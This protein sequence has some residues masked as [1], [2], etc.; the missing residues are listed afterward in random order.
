MPDTSPLTGVALAQDAKFDG[1]ISYYKE[2]PIGRYAITEFLQD[3]G[4]AWGEKLELRQLRLTEKDTRKLIALALTRVREATIHG[5]SPVLFMTEEGRQKAADR[6]EVEEMAYR[7]CTVEELWQ[8]VQSLTLEDKA[9][10]TLVNLVEV[11]Q[12]TGQGIGEYAIPVRAGHVRENI[13]AK[14]LHPMAGLIYGC[15]PVEVHVVMEYLMGEGLVSWDPKL[16]PMALHITPKGYIRASQVASGKGD[17]PPRGFVVCRFTDGLNAVYDAVYANVLLPTGEPVTL[18]R[19]KDIH[20][21]EKIDDKIMAEIRAA[22]FVLVDLSDNNFNIGF[23]AGYA[24]ALGKPIVFTMQNSAGEM[25]LPF[26]IQSHNIL[27]YDAADHSEFKEQ[28]PFRI[29]AALDKASEQLRWR[30]SN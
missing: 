17:V 18:L 3:H 29:A 15:Q 13:W 23:E 4:F 5:Q 9:M 1:A 16:D 28:L 11:E 8:E 6:G 12:N 25:K 10:R 14:A 27:V 2:P 20:H 26:D 24:L 19:V 7:I 21:V 22:S 30:I